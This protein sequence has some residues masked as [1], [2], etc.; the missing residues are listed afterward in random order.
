M[1]S[2]GRGPYAKSAA[3]R[4]RILEACTQAFG[5]SGFHGAAMKDIA[6]R[7]EISLTGLLHHFPSKAELLMAV[8]EFRADQGRRVMEECGARDPAGEPLKALRGVLAVIAEN[9]MHPGLVEL[10]CVV[11]SEATSPDHPAHAYYT[12]RFVLLR[13]FYIAVFTTLRQRGEL[14]SALSPAALSTMSVSLLNGLQAQWLYDRE[15]VDVAQSMR[16]FLVSVVPAL[17]DPE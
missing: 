16:E 8:L 17:A 5:Q 14:R 3:V 4:V 1:S 2:A 10:H 9:A 15:G 11:S 12:Q 6:G 13:R 7:A